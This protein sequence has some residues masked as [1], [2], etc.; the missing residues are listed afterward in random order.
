MKAARQER[1]LFYR[2]LLITMGLSILALSFLGGISF[3]DEIWAAIAAIA[4][5]AFLANF[6]LTIFLGEINVIFVVTL[7]SGLI[8]GIP[9]TIWITTV[10]TSL[11]YIIRRFYK[12]IQ[13]E[14]KFQIRD[15]WFDLGFNVA[16][17]IVPL[18]LAFLILGDPET[19]KLSAVTES[20]WSVAILP[21]LA[22]VILHS[23]LLWLD[24]LIN[25]GYSM[26]INREDLLFLL[27]IELLP[28]P[29]LLIGAEAYPYVGN[30]FIVAIG[31]IPAVMA[32]LLYG[33]TAARADMQKRVREL[34]TLSQV[35]QTLRSSLDID[36]LL[37]TIQE[38][39]MQVLGVSN[40]F[41]ALVDSP[42]NQL[43]Y[44]LAVKFGE[45]V[46][47]PRR[48]MMDRLTDRVIREGEA[49]KLT[50]QTQSGPDPV[51]LP[52]S[53][54]T[55]QSW[56]GVPLVT[57]EGVIGCLAVFEILEGVEFSR[58]DLDL[59]NTLSASVS[60]AIQNALLYDQVQERAAQLEILYQLT[61]QITASLEV[62]AVMDQVCQ[63]VAQVSG[64]QRSAIYLYDP[65]EDKV[66][67][68]A[69][70]GLSEEFVQH[71]Q[72]FS[73]GLGRRTRSMRT[74]KVIL[75]PNVSETSLSIE[76]VRSLRVDNILAYADFPLVT[77]D[78]QIGF[79]SVFHDQP[80]DFLQ[81]EVDL[82]QTFAAQAAL[83][84]ANAQLHTRTDEKLTRR[85]H[86]LAMLESVSRELSAATHSDQLFGL[87]LDYALEFT[88]V[89]LGAIILP[90]TDSGVAQFKAK[91]GF[92]VP[93]KMVIDRGISMRVMRSG[94]PENIGDVRDDPD[95]YDVGDGDT[96]S[97]LSVPLTH[98]N[99]V[100]GVLTLES[101]ILNAFPPNEQSLVEQLANQA[102]VALVNANLYHETQ[103]HLREQ[104]TLFQITARLVEALDADST[105]EILCQALKAVVAPQCL[106]FY[107]LNQEK[108]NFQQVLCKDSLDVGWIQSELE[109]NF[110]DDLQLDGTKMFLLEDEE[111]LRKII[112]DDS[113][114]GKNTIFPMQTAQ[115]LIGFALLN[116][117]TEFVIS[118][119]LSKLIEAIV[120]QGAIAIQNAQLF[121][122]TAQ[123]REQL[124]AVIN[125]V[126]E[127]IIMVD[128]EGIVT[129]LNQPLYMLTGLPG[130][131]I[132]QK[133]LRDLSNGV[134]GRLGYQRKDLIVELENLAEGNIPNS[135]REVY[136]VPGIEP[137]SVI[138]RS[139]YPVMDIG[140]HVLGWM[141]VWRDVTEEH[142]INQERE[143]IADALIHDLRSPISAVLGA[144]D[145]LY[146]VIPEEEVSRDLVDRSLQVARRGAKRVLRLVMSLLDV[147]RMQSGRIEL[148]RTP[149]E[150]STLIPE[151]L[152]D[153]EIIAD[154]YNITVK[155][156]IKDDIPVIFVDE[157][158]ISRVITNLLDNA[159]KF[160]PEFGI[161]RVIGEA[162]E[163]GVILQIWDQ[164]PGISE[165][166]RAI[167]FERFSQISG[168]FGR[169]RGAGLGLAFSRLTAEAH[170][171]TI[172][173]EPPPDGVGSVFS[174]TLPFR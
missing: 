159:V 61:G 66:H 57:P 49:I 21:A 163:G 84:V 85:V 101:D 136:Q 119:N 153:I 23:L 123:R 160:S 142:K 19:I 156:E 29:L 110:L 114:G 125:S 135:T 146:D 154:E 106:G 124:A 118:D 90:D 158:K 120:A 20:I 87:V 173:V 107:F 111:Y 91:H 151:L 139:S 127:S 96:R 86:Q 41:V 171:G 98:K 165:E 53:E 25:W 78:G 56:L 92:R 11:G 167:I 5:I 63:A 28:V 81:A 102:A 4:F 138:E 3:G 68:A 27:V 117:P 140:D 47:W 137:V 83:A 38:Q 103:R 121:V 150:I 133:H 157:D 22:F 2:A 43:W 8:F 88:Q 148:N 39:V 6:P 116:L 144:I 64:S 95:F 34:S 112:I 14:S 12:P 31:G 54:A 46:S 134:L 82:L 161:V 32:V 131:K 26:M 113:L 130:E 126:A 80:H 164:G 42:K 109:G 79:L 100:L 1:R 58:F 75:T 15:W 35:S 17:N 76:L 99:E 89:P 40:F 16:I 170:G 52:P 59:L 94:E 37:A 132:I 115:R 77:P 60:I 149:V 24:G 45:R 152:M 128:T 67:L 145:L 69:F 33:A 122:E 55:P 155:N 141:I 13:R 168:Q 10:G 65:G 93:E 104:S 97:Q 73:I 51:G 169:W 166:Y 62:N 72:E 44:P 108:Y 172:W 18:T 50:P 143:A 36:D 71:S 129:L 74:G 70:Y 48:P 162:T 9:Q 147:A 105:L 174:L 30:I 7:G